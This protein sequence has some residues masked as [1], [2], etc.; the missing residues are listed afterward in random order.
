MVEAKTEK[1]KQK[2]I[3]LILKFEG[4]K[5]EECIFH[6]DEGTLIIRNRLTGCDIAVICTVKSSNIPEQN[7]T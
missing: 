2:A 4:L 3:D 7:N 1:A 6:E 5:L